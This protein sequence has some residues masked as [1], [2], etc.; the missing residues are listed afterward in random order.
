MSNSAMFLRRIKYLCN[1]Y[2]Y[3]DKYCLQTKKSNINL[4]NYIKNN[5]YK[6]T[7]ILCNF[8]ISFK[9]LLIGY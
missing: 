7:Y 8:Y 4:L 6:K 3:F 9:D 5:N 2:R 1:N